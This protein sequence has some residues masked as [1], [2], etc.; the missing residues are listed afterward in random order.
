MKKR[1]IHWLG[2]TGILALL[3]YAAAVVF[4]P[5]AYPGYNWMAQAVSDLS[6]EAAPSRQLW[7]RLAAP[8]NVCGVVCAT[9]VALFVSQARVSSRLL[10]V[11]LYLFMAMNWVSAVGYGMFP[12]AGTDTVVALAIQSASTLY[13]AYRSAFSGVRSL[14]KFSATGSRTR[15]LFT[16]D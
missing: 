7:N 16:M 8:Y 4:S 3:S 13:F 2:L 12:L 5:M 11:G 9:S 1:L 10:R 15:L 14:M 6:A